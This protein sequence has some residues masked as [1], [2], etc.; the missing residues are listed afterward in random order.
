[1]TDD[2]IDLVTFCILILKTVT[3]MN[4]IVVPKVVKSFISREEM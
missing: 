4:Y 1:M 2:F 3:Y